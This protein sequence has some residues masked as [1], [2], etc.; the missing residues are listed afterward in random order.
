[1]KKV[2][3]AFIL[4]VSMF[5]FTSC[6]DQSS[7]KFVKN[8]FYKQ[9]YQISD[10]E[11]VSFSL[12]K[13]LSWQTRDD[14]LPQFDIWNVKANEEI[15]NMIFFYATSYDQFVEEVDKNRS[16]SLNYY[17][18]LDKE[19][20]DEKLEIYNEEY[21][22]NNIL[23]FYYK[24]EPNISK[25]YIYNVIIKE[26]S[27]LLNV[28]RFEGM[29]TALSSWCY[30]V[31]IKKEDVENVTDFNVAVRTIS[32]LK[33][34]VV[35]SVKAEYIRDMYINGLTVDD[36]PG[37]NNLKS[38]NVWTWGLKLDIH[39]NEKISDERL[40]EIIDF[41]RASENIRSVGYTSNTWIRVTV[42][43]KFYDK[44][45]NKS[46]SLE[47]IIGDEI[48]NIDKF[49]I[50]FLEPASIAIITLEMEQHGKQ[51]YEAMINQ[52]KELNYSFID[53]D[54]IMTF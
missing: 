29:M 33:S 7:G 36:F 4:I 22:E 50:K 10:G 14:S 11:E 25:N 1:M 42:S 51:Y 17:R 54:S 5:L 49:S 40:N 35:V 47:D 46:L 28:N 45:V 38:V 37:L 13:G 52:L 9:D 41:L 43:D 23:L 30:F 24:Y 20:W 31:T 32:E 8:Y 16:A 48:E 15:P 53:Y 27:L 34:S 26:N 6:K 18:Y 44:F 19:D 12:N 39:F 3:C 21:F 2:L